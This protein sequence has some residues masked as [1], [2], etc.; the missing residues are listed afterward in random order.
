MK[1]AKPTPLS[2]QEFRS[3]SGWSVYKMSRET[4]IPTGSLRCYLKEPTH[5]SYREPKPYI[6]HLFGLLY[7]RVCKTETA[8]EAQP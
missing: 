7:E 2:P 5:P 3:L 4:E 8:M 6:N 1:R